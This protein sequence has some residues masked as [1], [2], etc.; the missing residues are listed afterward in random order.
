MAN[1]QF[2]WIG[3]NPGL[4]FCNTEP[5]VDGHSVDLLADV[6]DLDQWLSAAGVSDSGRVRSAEVGDDTLAWARR[7]R[8][9]LREFLDPATRGPETRRRLNSVLAEVP[10]TAAIDESGRLVLHPAPGRP[11]GHGRRQL[12]LL[13]LVIGA[14]ALDPARVRRCANPACVLLF[15]DKSK[16]GRR[17]WHDMASCGNRAK[18]ATHYARAHSG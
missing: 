8:G 6:D 4:D 16:S 7:L 3:N 1:R 11:A 17:R 12:D 18:A 9:A 2:L 13:L 14:A 15:Y 5:V 10:A